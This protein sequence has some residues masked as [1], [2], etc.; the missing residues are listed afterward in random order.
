LVPA[1]HAERRQA[2][3]PRSELAL[4]DVAGRMVPYPQITVLEAIRK[5]PGK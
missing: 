4:V 3:L 5:F 1:L 2:L